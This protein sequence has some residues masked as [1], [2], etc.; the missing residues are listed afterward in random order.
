MKTLVLIA[1]LAVVSSAFSADPKT[2]GDVVGRDL[3]AGRILGWIGHVGAYTGS[4]VLE[5]LNS[6]TPVQK[7]TLSSFK[8]ATNYWGSRYV[9][10]SVMSYNFQLVIDK[11]WDQRNY[12]PTYTKTIFYTA[13]SKSTTSVYNSTTK[14][15]ETKTVITPAKFRCDTFIIYSFQAGIG[16]NLSGSTISPWAVYKNCPNSR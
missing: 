8:T 2:V 4:S 1:S 16:Y 7:N 6:P 9:K 12:N 10:S 3:N 5:V 15:Y 14:K 13:G 11:G